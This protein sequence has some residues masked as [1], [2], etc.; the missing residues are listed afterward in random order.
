MIEIK[1]KK[2]PTGSTSARAYKPGGDIWIDGSEQ[3]IEKLRSTPA[4]QA[5]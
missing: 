5:K 4:P 2:V 1:N 3:Q